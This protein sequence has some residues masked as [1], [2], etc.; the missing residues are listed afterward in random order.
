MPSPCLV[1]CG[2]SPKQRQVIY[3][4]IGMH[5]HTF[6][7]TRILLESQQISFP[8][9]LL[10]LGSKN[11]Y[12]SSSKLKH[13]FAWTLWIFR[14]RFVFSY[15]YTCIWNSTSNTVCARCLKLDSLHEFSLQSLCFVPCW[16]SPKKR[17]QKYTVLWK[18]LLSFQRNSQFT[19]I[20]ANM[21]SPDL[22]STWQERQLEK[23]NMAAPIL[24]F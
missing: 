9:N 20:S 17:H 5:L 11:D 24:S 8:L 4:F 15:M 23:L 22:V 2:N 19:G 3:N 16:N 14:I 21:F 13:S 18:R 10:I 1:P 12:T 7:R 6:H